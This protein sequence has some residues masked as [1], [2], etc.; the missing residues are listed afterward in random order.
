MADLSPLEAEML[1]PEWRRES[2]LVLRDV[3][4]AL[5]ANPLD[6]LAVLVLESGR[7]LSPKARYPKDPKVAPF[8]AGLT[9]ITRPAAVEAGFIDRALS[10]DD[11]KA[12]Y[13]PFARWVLGLNVDNQLQHVVVPQM[14]ATKWFKEGKPFATGARLYLMNF[15]A[16]KG[17]LPDDPSAVIAS[18]GDT[19]YEGNKGLDI[20]VP[21]G[22]I[23]MGDLQA[24][25]DDAR[26]DPVYRAAAQRYIEAVKS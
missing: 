19:L 26:R 5:R 2:F 25:V 7:T 23:T 10:V 20:L 22:S 13:I 8:A 18:K 1:T 15:A 21:H 17:D 16:G 4:K 9:Q 6:I 14:Q 12:A 24:A 3:G 11:Q